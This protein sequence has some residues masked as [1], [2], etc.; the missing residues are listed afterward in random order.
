MTHTDCFHPA[1]KAART[2]CRKH[3]AEVEARRAAEAAD[4]ARD[5]AELARWY[6]NPAVFADHCS[7]CVDVAMACAEENFTEEFMIDIYEL[8]HLGFTY[9]RN[10]IKDWAAYYLT[11][12]IATCYC[13]EN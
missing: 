4:H 12:G 6:L 9:A 7:T 8:D 2:A 5:D 1:T 3:R 11:D 10:T 13:E